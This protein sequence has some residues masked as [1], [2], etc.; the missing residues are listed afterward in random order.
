[1]IHRF[2]T[3]LVL[4][5]LPAVAQAHAVVVKASQ[6]GLLVRVEV[7]F[8]TEDPAEDAEVF[9]VASDGRV[10]TQGKTDRLGQFTFPTP[11]SG[12]Y[13]IIA[14]AGS[15]HR[16]TAKLAIVL[17][18]TETESVP[19]KPKTGST[20]TNILLGL[21]FIVAMTLL[22]KQARARRRKAK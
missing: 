16:A 10:V 5:A 6:R 12:S 14:D 11:K 21:L 3:L 15:G 9:I 13:E 7:R 17:N 20:V 1:M 19:D 8:D 2:V 22:W 4:L 18:R